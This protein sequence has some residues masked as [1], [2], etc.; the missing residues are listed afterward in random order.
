MDPP[1]VPH[2]TLSHV[3][4]AVLKPNDTY[5]LFIDNKSEKSG[6]MKND[7]EPPFTPPEEID[8]PNDLRPDDW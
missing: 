6:N 7:F 5:E 3:Y 2:D 1:R 8:D 4:T